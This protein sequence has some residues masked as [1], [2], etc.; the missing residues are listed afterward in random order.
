MRA[1]R[2]GGMIFFLCLSVHLFLSSLAL[3]AYILVAADLLLQAAV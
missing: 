2:T 1:K 3:T